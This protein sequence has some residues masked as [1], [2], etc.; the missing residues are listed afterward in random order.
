MIQCMVHPLQLRLSQEAPWQSHFRR[1]SH[2]HHRSTPAR[3][4][5][6][7]CH[8]TTATRVIKTALSTNMLRMS[9]TPW[10]F[11]R[12]RLRLHLC[13]FEHLHSTKSPLPP[14]FLKSHI[15]HTTLAHQASHTDRSRTSFTLLLTIPHRMSYKLK[16]LTTATSQRQTKIIPSLCLLDRILLH[17]VAA[18]RLPCPLQ[19]DRGQLAS[20]LP[21]TT[22]RMA[23]MRQVPCQE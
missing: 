1:T 16:L 21:Q 9:S 22:L 4:S 11:T 2:R 3:R 17:Q 13:Q 15:P 14:C 23:C 19:A 8:A 10:T 5:P 20:Q 6:L 18:T 12:T 7:L